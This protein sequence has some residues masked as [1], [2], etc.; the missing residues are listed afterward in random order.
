MARQTNPKTRIISIPAAG[1]SPVIIS[2]SKMCRYVEIEE[3]PP[4]NFDNNTHA[5]APQGLLFQLPDDGYTRSYGLVPGLIWSIGDKD[6]RSKPSV[7]W[8]GGNDPAGNAIPATPYMQALSATAT[9]TQVQVRE[10]S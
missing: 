7:A 4:A 2:A 1:G 6:W 3:C 9:A 10:W 5:F 8:A